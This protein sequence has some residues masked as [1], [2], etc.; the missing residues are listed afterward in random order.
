MDDWSKTDVLALFGVIFTIL[1]IVIAASKPGGR[2]RITALA[3]MG[4]FTVL[5][6][7]WLVGTLRLKNDTRA[8]LQPPETQPSPS[9]SASLMPS[10]LPLPTPKSSSTPPPTPVPTRETLTVL[11]PTPQPVRTPTPALKPRPAP[12]ELSNTRPA[13]M[14]TLSFTLLDHSEPVTGARVEFTAGEFSTTAYTRNGRATARVPCGVPGMWINFEYQGMSNSA[15]IR[16]GLKCQG[17]HFEAGPIDLGAAGWQ[18]L[19]VRC[20]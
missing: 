7:V 2:L 16:R 17:C 20:G 4:T 9:P 11:S 13:G 1:G 14:V 10:P 18:Y 19:D 12:Q 6:I 5:L 3:V 8:R 15:P